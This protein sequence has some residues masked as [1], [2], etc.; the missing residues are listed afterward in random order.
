MQI[1]L[2]SENPFD[3]ARQAFKKAAPPAKSYA[4]H[5]A[6]FEKSALGKEVAKAFTPLP[7]EQENKGLYH[8]AGFVSYACQIVS[9]SAAASFVFAFILSRINTLPGAW[10]V[11]FAISAAALF[12][13]EF[14]L[15]KETPKLSRTILLSGFS[16]NI[17]RRTLFV[18]V[19]T[20]AGITSSYLGGFDTA[21]AVA[22]TPPAFIAPTPLSATFIDTKQIE[23]RYATQIADAKAAAAEYKTRRLWKNRLSI[24]DGNKYRKLLAV[25]TN[26]EAELNAE[27]QAAI[28]SNATQRENTSIENSKREKAAQS[29]HNEAVSIYENRINDNGGGLARLSVFAQLIFFCCLFY[30]SHYLIETAK[31]YTSP[32]TDDN[33]DGDKRTKTDRYEPDDFEEILSNR[34]ER[35]GSFLN[36]AKMRVLPRNQSAQTHLTINAT[37]TRQS[38]TQRTQTVFVP[39]DLCIEHTDRQTGK[40]KRLNISQVR[41]NISANKTRL[42]KAKE[43]GS[44]KQI[45]N[46]ELILGYWWKREEEL[47][48]A[49]AALEN[50]TAV[51]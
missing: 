30:R 21:A 11:A 4:E 24:A 1:N 12:V 40:I 46:I 42:R 26:K 29:A 14:L 33:P 23:E 15:R 22:E 9:V 50:T 41:A 31:Q 45:E 3:K 19:L 6:N 25:A 16:A 48:E 32:T 2:N 36:R 35:N 27:I 5:K 18:L 34:N 37:R 17:W 39:T 28:A 38:D 43:T 44:G 51:C 20:A 7:Y 13:I 8:T 10:Y 47:I 49:A